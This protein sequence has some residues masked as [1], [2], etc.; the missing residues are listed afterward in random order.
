MEENSNL[1]NNNKNAEEKTSVLKDVKNDFSKQVN[2]EVRKIS[3]KLPL[4]YKL[5]IILGSLLIVGIVLYS[6]WDVLFINKGGSTFTITESTLT[7]IIQTSDLSTLEFNYNAIVTVNTKGDKPEPMYY[8]AY[9]GIVTAGIDLEKVKVTKDDKNITII[10]PN[11]TIQKCNVIAENMDF[12]FVKDKY[13]NENVAH[14]AYKIC[15]DDLNKRA[16]KEDDLL[17]VAKD[18][19]A[20]AIE[21]LIKP[22]I[23][24]LDEG[25]VVEV[26]K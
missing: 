23:S 22:W 13:N 12:I 20:K 16:L 21:S 7:D 17:K 18:N 9:E 19:A 4:K 14:E 1:N 2:S 8:V 25:Y 24:A 10:V 11:A 26:I 15:V 3:K 5:I 6:L